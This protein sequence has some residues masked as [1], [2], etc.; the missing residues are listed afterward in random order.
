M[1]P[2][3]EAQPVVPGQGPEPREAPSPPST[4]GQTALHLLL[5]EAANAF[6]SLGLEVF[7]PLLSGLGLW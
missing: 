5:P 3:A 1:H 2:L 4:Q 7:L 6:C